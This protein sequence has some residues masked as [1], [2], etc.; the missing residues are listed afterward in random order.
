MLISGQKTFTNP[1]SSQENFQLKM[2][3]HIIEKTDTYKY[4]G[5]IF[6]DKL[7]WNHQIDTICSKLSTVCGV[8]SK[9]RHYLD[10]KSLM[11]I[12]NSLFDSRLRYGILGWGTATENLVSKVKVLQNK[13]VRYITFSEFGTRST[14]MYSALDIVPFN[15]QL[16]LQRSIVMHSLYYKNIPFALSFYC[17]LPQHDRSTRYKSNRN[18]IL[19]VAKTVR[20]QTSMKFAGPKAWTSV[21]N[22]IKEIAYRK[23]FSK[24]LKKFIL[25]KQRE[26]NENL[27][28]NSYLKEKHKKKNKLKTDYVE[29]FASDSDES[30]FVGF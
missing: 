11:M 3:T 9:V 22:D 15:D 16:F 29:M 6:D 28:E 13:V 2:G 12:Y 25:E 14:T 30:D 21:P 20:S 23:P 4:L 5:I 17:K 18:F 26:D 8:I 27:P 19:P 7:N 24:R 1:V 10:R